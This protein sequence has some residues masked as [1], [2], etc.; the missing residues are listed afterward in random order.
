[1]SDTPRKPTAFRLDSIRVVDEPDIAHRPGDR[2]MVIAEPDEFDLPVPVPKPRRGP[3][4]A[5]I[6]VSALGVLLSL[7]I[8]LAVDQLIRD[9]FQIVCFLYHCQ[10]S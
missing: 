1:M 5:N 4:W 8:G 9:L 3:R 2:P 6:L 10:S 7:A